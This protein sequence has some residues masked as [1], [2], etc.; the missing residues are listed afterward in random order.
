MGRVAA[1]PRSVGGA[2]SR[3]DKFVAK[4]DRMTQEMRDHI[5]GSVGTFLAFWRHYGEKSSFGAL[6]VEGLDSNLSDISTA[7][8]LIPLNIDDKYTCCAIGSGTIT[9]IRIRGDVDIEGC[10]ILCNS[11]VYVLDEVQIARDDE[12]GVPT[13][14]DRPPCTLIAVKRECVTKGKQLPSWGGRSISKE[15]FF[16]SEPTILSQNKLD[17]KWITHESHLKFTHSH[18]V[19]CGKGYGIR[20]S[21]ARCLQSKCLQCFTPR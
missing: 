12:R 18:A 21:D 19:V 20:R 7:T 9:A 3:R 6:F 8:S 16:Y 10:E 13:K 15:S 5:S 17:K 14:E 2:G 4:S 1:V 11:L